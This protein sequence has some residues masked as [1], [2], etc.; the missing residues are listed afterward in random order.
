MDLI[1][2]KRGML[3]KVAHDL[4]ITRAAVVKWD[5]VPAERLPEIEEIT[6][7]PRHELR[8]DICPPPVEA[9]AI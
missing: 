6:G 8:P 9:E 1:R 5:K 4:G 3:A 2:A 7:I